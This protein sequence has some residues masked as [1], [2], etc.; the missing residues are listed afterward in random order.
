[1]SKKRL[2]LKA[3]LFSP[4]CLLFIGGCAQ[5]KGAQEK[6]LI[7]QRKAFTAVYE[8]GVS[9]VSPKL[10]EQAS[11]LEDF[12]TIA[13]VLHPRVKAAYYDWIA[14]IE[15]ITAARS[16]PDMQLTFQMDLSTMVNAL[17]PGL[18]QA[19]PGPGK[20]GLRSE[21]ASAESSAKYCQFQAVLL[22]AALQLKQ[23]YYKLDSNQKQ[24]HITKRLLALQLKKERVSLSQNQ[25]AL[26]PLSNALT[27]QEEKDSLKRELKNLQANRRALL[28]AWKGALGLGSDAPNPAAPT[29]FEYAPNIVGTDIFE[30]AL[31]RNPQLNSMKAELDRAESSLQ[32]TL[33]NQIPDFIVGLEVDVRGH[34]RFWPN[35][36]MTLPVWREKIAAEIHDAMAVKQASEQRVSNEKIRLAT[37]FAQTLFEFQVATHN[38]HLLTHSLLPK[39]KQKFELASINNSVALSDF[40]VLIDVQKALLELKLQ[41][42]KAREEQE[43]ALAKLSLLIAG[44]IPETTNFLTNLR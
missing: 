27:F 23:V 41:E 32:L 4:W 42:A 18:M 2:L 8:Q 3:F 25:V 11:S 28:A 12:L 40:M 34:P 1:M 21:I 24:I 13:I 35:F 29:H 9:Q 7:N 31:Q 44:I 14:S 15:R 16:L 43:I 22:D 33:K 17:M 38:L 37:E 5:Q 19:F 39:A 20:L 26:I 36:N 30:I 10:L 6:H